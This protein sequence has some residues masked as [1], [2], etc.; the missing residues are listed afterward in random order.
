VPEVEYI[1]PGVSDLGMGL[2]DSS[3]VQ[4]GYGAGYGAGYGGQG[5]YGQGSYES[6]GERVSEISQHMHLLR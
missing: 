1:Q 5:A 3:Y 4:G 6:Y 2:R